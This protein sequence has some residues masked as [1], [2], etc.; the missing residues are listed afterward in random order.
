MLCRSGPG[1]GVIRRDAQIRAKWSASAI[2]PLADRKWFAKT[3]DRRSSYRAHPDLMKKLFAQE[4][5]KLRR[6]ITIMAPPAIRARAPTRRIAAIRP[7]G[8]RLRR[9]E[10]KPRAAVV[11]EMQGEKIASFLSRHSDFGSTQAA[12]NSPVGIDEEEDGWVVGARTLV[13]LAIAARQNV[14]L[15][16]VTGRRRYPAGRPR[17]AHPNSPSGRNVPDGGCG[18]TRAVAGRRSFTSLRKSPIRAGQIAAIEGSRG[19]AGECQNRAQ[20]G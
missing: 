6:I 9:H 14:R 11:Q 20:E 1:E 2:Q 13:W 19:L 3:A 7:S 5:L 17:K 12:S 4:W 18:R 16:P 10:G 8:R 15:P